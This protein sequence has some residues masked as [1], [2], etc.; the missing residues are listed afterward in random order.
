MVRGAISVSEHLQRRPK[1]ALGEIWD[2]LGVLLEVVFNVFWKFFD[3]KIM[4]ENMVE[5]NDKIIRRF[6]QS[7]LRSALHGS[8]P[9]HG[10]RSFGSS[11]PPSRTSEPPSRTSEPPSRTSEPPS[12]TLLYFTLLDFT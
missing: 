2:V 6:F 3:L 8:A 10:I 7:I 1:S 12:R 4:Y 9:K 5:T 11:E